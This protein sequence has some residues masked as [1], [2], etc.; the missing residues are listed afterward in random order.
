M[1][2]LVRLRFGVI[3][4]TITTSIVGRSTNIAIAAWPGYR[5]RVRARVRVR[6]RA[7]VSVRAEVH[8]SGSEFRV[9]AH[10]VITSTIVTSIVGRSTRTAIGA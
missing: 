6:V 7:R 9:S 8:V 2:G 4:N 1:L 5:V 10:H 3:S